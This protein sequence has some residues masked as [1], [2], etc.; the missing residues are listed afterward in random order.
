MPKSNGFRVPLNVSHTWRFSVELVWLDIFG[1]TPSASL[2]S[3]FDFPTLETKLDLGLS[4][5]SPLIGNKNCQSNCPRCFLIFLECKR[6]K[7]W[8]QVLSNVIYRL[9]VSLSSLQRFSLCRLSLGNPNGRGLWKLMLGSCLCVV[10]WCI[11]VSPCFIFFGQ[12]R[13]GHTLQ[14][15]L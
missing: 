4:I 1:Q 6:Q 15:I 14:I 12:L 8:M 5:H 13:S 10:V 3:Q 9:N 2:H 11:V 7:T